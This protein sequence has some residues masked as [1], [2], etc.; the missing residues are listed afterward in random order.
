M[1]NN[2]RCISVILVIY[3]PMCISSLIQDAYEASLLYIY[4][5]KD[6]L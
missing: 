5:K 3:E 4:T 1:S 6:H 2:I